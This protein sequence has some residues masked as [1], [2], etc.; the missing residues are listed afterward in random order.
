MCA[1]SAIGLRAGVSGRR[2][3]LKHFGAG[4]DWFSMAQIS[5]RRMIALILMTVLV[6]GGTVFTAATIAR[7]SALDAARQQSASELM[8]TAM[9]NQETGA[10]GYFRLLA[11]LSG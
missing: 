10:R 1:C 7:R 3:W 2:A 6:I 9:L 4:V 8:M 5:V 11:I